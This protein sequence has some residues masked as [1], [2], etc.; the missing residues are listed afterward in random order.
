MDRHPKVKAIVS[1]VKGAFD[2]ILAAEPI[3]DEEI[4][5]KTAS[6]TD[7]LIVNIFILTVMNSI[8]NRTSK[9]YIH[10]SSERS[11]LNRHL[12]YCYV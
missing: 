4:N 7:N 1:K 2:N 3:K 10:K 6:N 5:V 9:G 12:R 11:E 8:E